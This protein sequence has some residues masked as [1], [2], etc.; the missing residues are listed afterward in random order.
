MEYCKSKIS[1]EELLY[2]ILF[3][4]ILFTKGIGLDEGSPL[5][6]CCLM[7]AIL[8]L[9]CKF[10]MGKYSITELIIVGL[11]GIWG[12]FTFKVTGSLGMFIYVIL[13]IGMKNVS[14]KRVFTV[15]MG[16]WSLCML[17]TVTAAV[18]FGRTGVRVIHEKLGLGPILRESLGYTHPNVLHI[19]YIVLITFTLYLCR[20]NQKKFFTAAILLLLGD[21]YI[22]LYSVSFTGLLFSFALFILFFY[23]QKRKTFSRIETV[24]IEGMPVLCI[25]I[26]IVLPLILD[27][28]ILY[29]VF[30]KILNNRV[31]AIR[32]FFQYY[33]V[34][35]FGGGNEGIE[36][37]LDNSYVSAL[38][39]YGMIPLA[40][41]IL[42]YCLLLRYSLKKNRRMELT[43]ICTFLIAGLSEPFLFNASVKNITVVLIGELLYEAIGERG[44]V[45]TFFSAH[46]RS[47]PFSFDLWGRIRRWLGRVKWKTAVCVI[48]LTGMGCFLCL[49]PRDCAGIDRVYADERL[50]HVGGETVL[51]PEEPTDERT[52]YIGNKSADINYY[53]FSRENSKLIEIVDLRIKV[54]VSLYAAAA[55]GA[56]FVCINGRLGRKDG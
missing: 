35:F 42:T 27:D 48:L 19:T 1:L 54:S 17:Y 41:I 22:F 14:V 8:L 36:F 20:E 6:R 46:N 38:N 33:Q 44:Y 23:F 50:C 52:L 24:I 13:I 7:F 34:T 39:G 26:S 37:S 21:I 10:L 4:I 11:L 45:F 3:S 49:L 5:F 43:I 16:V 28:G 47:F 53:F 55:A 56:L 25:I 12:V 18:F 40:I 9:A 31:W 51:L 30:N 32:T 29:K 15:G 2:D